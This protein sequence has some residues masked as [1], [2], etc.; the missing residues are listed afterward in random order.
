MYVCVM[1]ETIEISCLFSLDLVKYQRL[2]E[3]LKSS[4]LVF[5]FNIL[6]IKFLKYTKI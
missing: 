1:T 5:K 3:K 6:V 2:K 4:F